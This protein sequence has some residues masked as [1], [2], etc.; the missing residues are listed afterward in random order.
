MVSKSLGWEFDVSGQ[1]EKDIT[2][3]LCVVWQISD[4]HIFSLPVTHHGDDAYIEVTDIGETTISE[5][6]ILNYDVVGKLRRRKCQ[7]SR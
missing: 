3:K 5:L 4:D 2:L 7:G 1:E 6:L